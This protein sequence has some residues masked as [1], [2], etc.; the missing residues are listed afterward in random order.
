MWNNLP[1][2]TRRLQAL[3][4][5]DG[6]ATAAL[7]PKVFAGLHVVQILRRDRVA[8]AVSWAKAAQD[9]VWVA[10]DDMPATP[11]AKPVYDFGLIRGLEG[12]IVEGEKG[13]RE[14]FRELELEPYEVVYEEL[15]TPEGYQGAVVGVAAYLGVDLVDVRLP[16]PRSHR[17][18]DQANE[19]WR[20]RYQQDLADVS[21][22]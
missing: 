9:G 20:K 15:A 13:W 19:E 3:P 2:V 1:W 5:F 11:S 6:L 8:Q 14:L 22:S 18:A 7:F 12:L 4:H 16:Q 17:Q 10:L 21:S